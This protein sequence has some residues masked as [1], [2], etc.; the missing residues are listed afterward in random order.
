MKGGSIEQEIGRTRPDY[1]A[2][3]PKSLTNANDCGNEHFLVFDLAP[4]VLGA[5]WTQSSFEGKPDQKIVFAR[6]FDAGR[7]WEAP[8]TV[9]GGNSDLKTGKDMCSWG[10]PL[11]SKSG[12]LYVIYN[13]HIGVNDVFTHTT[14]LMACKFSDDQGLRWSEETI[15]PMPRG[16]WDNPDS[17]IPRNWIVW[18]KPL[19]LADGR[20]L[21]GFTCWVS[22]KVRKPAPLPIWWAEEAVIEF[23]RFENIDENPSPS[24][25]K[26]SYLSVNEKALRVPIPSNA[27]TSCAQE[28]SL[29]QLPD[30]R[31]FCVMRTA[32]GSPYY[33][34]SNDC[35]TSWSSPAP[36]LYNDGAKALMHPVSPCPIYQYEQGK[37]VLLI[38]NHD[39]HFGNWGPMDS[40]WH[41]RPIWLL[42]GEFKAD[43]KQPVCFSD[44]VL[45][46]DNDGVPLNTVPGVRKS[47][48]TDLAM[49][50]SLTVDGRE[51]VLW[52]PERKFLLLG[53]RLD[54]QR[55]DDMEVD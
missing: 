25:I 31:I 36:L 52:Y 7:T 45:L 47:G 2:Y 29:V 49:Y 38:H 43:S 48:R 9:A 32:A 11:L 40:N 18:Q 26:I 39:G 53:K 5:V 19:R 27:E 34:V 4:G 30:G 14:G 1:V 35:G 42:K 21:T 51:P 50:S 8:R 37:Y 22:P 10:F 55:L 54:R 12:R 46:M 41:R 33:S 17:S 16:K 44:P 28:P 6:S 15:I 24:K 20:I 3:V 23:M 13:K